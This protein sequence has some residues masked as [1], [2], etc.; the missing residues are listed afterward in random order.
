M[1]EEKLFRILVL[2]GGP[3]VGSFHLPALEALGWLDSAL[4]VDRSAVSLAKLA[5]SIPGVKTRCADFREVLSDSTVA[6]AFDAVLVALPNSLHAVATHLALKVGLPVLC[7]KPLAMTAADCEGLRKASSAGA[8]LSVGMVMRWLPG[9]SAVKR[10]LAQ[11]MIG[12]LQSVDLEDGHP[13]AWD[14]ESGGY[15]TKANGGVLLNVGVHYLDLLGWLFGV[16]TPVAYRDDAAGGVEANAE[17]DLLAGALPVHVAV[18]YSRRLSNKLIVRG[19]RGELVFDKLRPDGCDWTVDGLSGR[20]VAEKPFMSADWERTLMGCFAEQ[21][22]VFA[23]AVTMR[24]APPV[25]ATDALAAALLIDWAMGHRSPLEP[26]L[27]QV[28]VSAE[29]V[30]AVKG[31]VMITGATGFVGTRLAGALSQREPG[32]EIIAL[33]RS[34]RSGCMAGRLPLRQLKGSLFDK[35]SIRTACQGVKHVFHLAYGADGADAAR[36]TIEG[37]LNVCLAAAEAGV[38]S[39]VVVGTTAVY[40]PSRSPVDETAPL[41]TTGSAYELAKAEMVLRVLELARGRAFGATR[42]VVLEPACIYGPGGRAFTEIPA[43]LAQNGQ[44]AWIEGGGGNAN[45]VYVDNFVDALMRAAVCEAA[46]GKRLIVQDCCLTWEV[47]LKGLLG[48]LAEGLSSV[49][50]VEMRA[51]SKLTQPGL[52]DLLNAALRCPELMTL[53]RKRTSAV[54]LAR[55]LESRAPSLMARLRG[56]RYA[57]PT[58]T[59]I[60][61]LDLESHKPVE[62]P[63]EWLLGLYGPGSPPLVNERVRKVL[64]WSP[65]VPLEVGLGR[66]AAWLRYVRLRP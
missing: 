3:V 58:G 66:A 36:V 15:F 2:G 23:Q 6:Q 17:F 8:M 27:H 55:A 44:L 16:L 57:K 21:L 1:L 53:V 42:V 30:R 34:F 39:V 4:V 60:K 33:V 31:M 10:A 26:E 41:R 5:E 63:P 19:S 7:E 28:D 18:S 62:L 49:S 32:D 12:E 22:A 40:G 46:H 20:L 11:R 65:R 47:F 29:A 45:M 38:D 37:T 54:W 14:S 59:Q 52:R 50:T 9:V 48:P 13:F 35:A 24:A 43:Q 64:G 25:P 61:R 56:A 51:G